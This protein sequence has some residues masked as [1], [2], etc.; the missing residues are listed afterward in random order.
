MTARDF[1]V[2]CADHGDM[3]RDEPRNAWECPDS[4]CSAW[5]P[6]SEVYRLVKGVPADSPDPVPIVVT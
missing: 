6:D 5:L 3:S 1:T 4:G 2:S